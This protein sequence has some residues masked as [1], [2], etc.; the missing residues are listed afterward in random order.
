MTE[1]ARN[2]SSAGTCART[3]RVSP[4]LVEQIDQLARGHGVGASRIA[5]LLLT[6]G[7]EEIASGQRRFRRKPVTYDVELD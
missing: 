1:E 5:G 4:A 6:I 7:L 3:Y 2:L